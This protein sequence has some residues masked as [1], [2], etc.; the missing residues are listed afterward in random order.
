MVGSDPGKAER[1][2][3]A[4]SPGSSG[5]FAL[6]FPISLRFV[7]IMILMVILTS[8]IAN[9]VV[10]SISR[11]S[12]RQ[13]ALAGNL[14]QATLA[15]DFAS[16]YIKAVHAHLEV[17]AERPDIRQAVLDNKVERLQGVLV[18]FVKVQ[19]ALD[20]TGIYDPDGVQLVSSVSNA[21]TIGQSFAD[22]E[23]FQGVLSTR[24]PYHGIPLKSRTTGH[25]VVPYG[26]PILDEQGQMRG[27]LV[28]SISLTALSEAIIA[29]NYGNDSRA[30]MVDSRSG[31]VIIA[32]IDPGRILTPVSGRNEAVKRLLTGER[33]TIETMSSAGELD[34]IGFVPVP[35][36]P[37]GVMVIT[38]SEK[39]LAIVSTL[40]RNAIIYTG[41]IILFAIIVGIVLT[42]GVTR[43]LRRLVVG[44][45]EIGRGNLDYQL[46]TTGRDEISELSHA[47]G[48]MTQELKQTLVS[49]DELEQRV[50][51]R[52]A[53]LSAV[54]KELE[55][56][57][58][59]V[60]H[61][62]RAPLR[63]IDGWSAAL[64]E[65]YQD[66]IDQR[67]RRYLDLVRSEVQKMGQLID[68]LLMF[69][70]QSRSEMHQKSLDLTAMARSIVSR[71]QQQ[72]P[73]FQADF[74]IQPGLMAQGDASMIDVVLANL[75]DNAVKFS[76][77]RSGA[78]IEFGQVEQEGRKAFFVRDNGVGFD[79]EYAHKLFGVFQRMHKASEFPGTG[80]GLA[81]VQRIINRHGGLIWA[82]SELS[83]GATFY[84][85]FKEVA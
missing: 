82:E 55:A 16:S 61:D 4:G 71:M 52:T 38:P 15:A 53:Q 6:R 54:N 66:K 67:G 42:L 27:M 34:M 73:T 83:K 39:A 20:S 36:L 46:A 64:L 68:D 8:G 9:F 11:D 12:L 44:A 80:I 14:S 2:N 85:T 3:G 41:V 77:R 22:R 63:G 65:E 84:F 75:F 76:S 26:V 69:S 56:F 37:W 50:I 57:G 32:H 40:T 79:M 5:R 48:Q 33:G 19:T 24:Q 35:D 45:K 47:F 72:N 51:E 70:R 21:T 7:G 58:Y 18:N 17:F 59:S 13:A 49:R 30:S 10:I 62:L 28:G 74:I 29:M 78:L 60:S 81:T 43:P 23:W 31:G 25:L 1:Q